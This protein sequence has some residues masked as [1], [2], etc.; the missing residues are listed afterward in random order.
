MGS[1]QGKGHHGDYWTEYS[2]SVATKCAHFHNPTLR[3]D[4]AQFVQIAPC[5]S[6]I[7]S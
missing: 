7:G 5:L 3:V 1:S 4:Q 6:S 2:K